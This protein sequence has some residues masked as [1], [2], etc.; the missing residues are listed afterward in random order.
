MDLIDALPAPLKEP[1]MTALWEQALDEVAAGRMRLEDFIARQTGW[2]RQLVAQGLVQNVTIRV[3]PT[4]LCPLCGSKTR[5]RRSE[6]GTFYSCEKYPA[7][8]GV[9][10]APDQGKKKPSKPKSRKSKQ[11]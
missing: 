8:K 3:P 7:C 11:N 4:P 6:K 2:T 10:N 1:G 9:V 5:L